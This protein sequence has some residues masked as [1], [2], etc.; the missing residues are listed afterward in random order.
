MQVNSTV[1]INDCQGSVERSCSQIL[2][3]HRG[4][5]NKLNFTIQYGSSH[6]NIHS[7]LK[8]M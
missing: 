8:A 2:K 6:V 7:S 1:L 5:T 4:L 3:L